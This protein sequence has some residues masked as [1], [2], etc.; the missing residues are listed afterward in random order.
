M[1]LAWYTIWK[2]IPA[3]E[4]FY[5]PILKCSIIP[6]ECLNDV[7]KLFSGFRYFLGQLPQTKSKIIPNLV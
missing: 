3:C 7:Y 4:L 5:Y 6:T 1:V 2:H